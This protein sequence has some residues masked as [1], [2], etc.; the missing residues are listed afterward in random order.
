MRTAS[1]KTTDTCINL[2]ETF[3]G[4]GNFKV[5]RRIAIKVKFTIDTAIIAT[6]KEE[7]QDMVAGCLAPEGGI[8]WKSIMENTS[9]ESTQDK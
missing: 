8:T 2:K 9:N 1:R 7:Q 4:G 5:G 6:T 3:T